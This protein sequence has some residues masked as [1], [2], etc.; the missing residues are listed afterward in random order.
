M[1]IA[2]EETEEYVNGHLKNKYGD[3]VIRGNNGNFYIRRLFLFFFNVNTHY[4]DHESSP[5]SALRQHIEE[6]TGRCQMISS[7]FFVIWNALGCGSGNL[8][9]GF[10]N[11]MVSAKEAVGANFQACKG[12]V[13]E[14][15]HT[16]F[17]LF[18]FVPL[19]KITIA[20][21]KYQNKIVQF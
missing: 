20:K 14:F 1:N 18:L 13:L 8:S 10:L 15:R 9:I 5:C 6:E 7:V 21:C 2:M 19:K 16:F 4:N 17:F 11:V 3:C 12:C